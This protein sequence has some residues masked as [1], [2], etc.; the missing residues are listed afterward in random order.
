MSD[1]VIIFIFLYSVMELW[2]DREMLI[3]WPSACGT[4][5]HIKIIEISKII[6]T[7]IKQLELYVYL[8]AW[9]IINVE[10]DFQALL[11][12]CSNRL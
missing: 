9:Q 7:S 2:S 4:G 5:I 12:T 8:G 6:V 3:T 11:L 10:V 1:L